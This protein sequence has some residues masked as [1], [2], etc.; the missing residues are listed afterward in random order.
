MFFFLSFSKYVNTRRPSLLN[1]TLV[2]CFLP[3]R[4]VS[5]RTESPLAADQ[6]RTEP[7][8]W[9]EMSVV[10]SRVNA[11]CS[12][13][14]NNTPAHVYD[15]QCVEARNRNKRCVPRCTPRNKRWC[16]RSVRV[17]DPTASACDRDC[18]WPRG[19]RRLKTQRQTPC[20]CAP[21][22]CDARHLF[23]HSTNVPATQQPLLI[24][25]KVYADQLTLLSLHAPKM[26]SPLG[27]NTADM[28]CAQQHA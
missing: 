3:C 1:T 19:C 8:K 22:M 23:P 27:L 6:K 10:P 17:A 16:A 5:S 25:T 28:T 4:A 14:T 13:T 24:A 18:R 2:T 9:P 12:N 11:T 26:Y 15:E 21:S 20:Q 7:S